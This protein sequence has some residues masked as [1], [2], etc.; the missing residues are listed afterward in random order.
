MPLRLRLSVA[1]I[2][3]VLA[4][5]SCYVHL[6]DWGA[7]DGDF[8]WPLRGARRF[9]DHMNPYDDPR[10]GPDYPYPA[11]AR[12]GYPMPALLIALPFTPLPPAAAGACFFGVSSGLLAFALSRRGWAPLLTL[13]S[14]PYFGAAG[15]AQWSPLTMAAVFLPA[16]YPAIAAK[17]NIGLAAAVAYPSA[18]GLLFALAFV[19]LS[20]AVYPPWVAGWLQNAGDNGAYVPP[21][22]ILPGPLLILAWLHWRLPSGRLLGAMSL[23][24]QLLAWADQLMLLLIPQTTRQYLFLTAASWVCYGGWLIARSS[25]PL[26]HPI[27]PA[28]IWVMLFYLIAL[29]LVLAQGH[30]LISRGD[31]RRVDPPRLPLGLHRFVWWW[32]PAQPGPGPRKEV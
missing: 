26:G 6:V 20:I 28:H 24:P 19:A 2:V 29:G 8:S 7:E 10:L 1:A 18:R 22:L 30:G 11:N 13:V 14:G 27:R 32:M 12:L 23:I 15:L 3:V 4:T 25:L 21:A 31:L 17:T 16:I 9:L 5:A